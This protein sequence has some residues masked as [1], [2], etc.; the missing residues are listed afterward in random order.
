MVLMASKCTWV[1][2][3]IAL[4]EGISLNSS[5]RVD[6]I[7]VESLSK[8]PSMPKPFRLSVFCDKLR[9]SKR[10]VINIK[11]MHGFD[12]FKVRVGQS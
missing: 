1:R 5:K 11:V 12:G 2:V 8:S 4:G 6:K 9:Q 3:I 10:Q 7:C